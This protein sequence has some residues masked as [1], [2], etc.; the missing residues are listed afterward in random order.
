M[1]LKFLVGCLKRT[2][3]IYFPRFSVKNACT[4]PIY[5]F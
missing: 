4:Y 1:P 2:S 5:L 3:D